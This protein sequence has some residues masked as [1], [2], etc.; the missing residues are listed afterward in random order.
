[1]RIGL[2]PGSFDPLTN[3]HL[4]IIQRSKV[5]CDKL[6][7][8]IGTNSAKN[9][10][11][12]INERIEIINTCCNDIAN[13]EV[14]TFNGLLAEYSK[15]QNISFIIRGLRSSTDF[16]YEYQIA[17]ANNKIAPDLETIFLMSRGEYFHI[18]SNIVKEIASYGGDISSMVPHYAKE[19][20]I[21]KY[22][23]HS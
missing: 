10:L 1:M 12:S 17:V 14:V 21:A 20:I 7:I 8:A 4:D 9:P 23:N 6:L 2:Y 5:I 19:K 13:I 11:F 16:D 3:G 15:K 18:S 22:S